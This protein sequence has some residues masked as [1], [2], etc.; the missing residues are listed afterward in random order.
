MRSPLRGF[1]GCGSTCICPEMFHGHGGT[2]HGL[3]MKVL[4]MCVKIF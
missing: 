3:I 4:Y 1:N 2:F